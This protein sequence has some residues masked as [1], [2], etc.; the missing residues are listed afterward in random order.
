MGLTARLRAA[1]KG[2]RGGGIQLNE[3]SG[4]LAGLGESFPSRDAAGLLQL[5]TESPWLRTVVERRAIGVGS[6]RWRLYVGRRSDGRLYRNERL[7]SMLSTLPPNDRRQ[8]LNVL[9]EQGGIVEIQNHGLLSVLGGGQ[10]LLIGLTLKQ[11]TS[12]Y[13]DI[14]GEAFWLLGRDQQFGF[15]NA[16]LPVPPHW[17]RKT[18]TA[19]NPYYE[20]NFRELQMEIPASEVIRFHNPNPLNPYARG[21]GPGMSV[22]NEL[23]IDEFMRNHIASFYHNRARPDVVVSGKDLSPAKTIQL[24]KRWLERMQG[25]FKSFLPFFVAGEVDVKPITQSFHEME[26]GTARKHQRDVIQQAFGLPPTIMGNMENPTRAGAQTEDFI[27]SKWQIEPALE[28]QCQTM[29]K[30]LVP[31]YDPGLL[32]GYDSPIARDNEFQLRAMIAMPNT[33]Q[34]NEWRGAQGLPPDPAMR[35]IYV[36]SNRVTT[37]TLDPEDNPEKFSATPPPSKPDD[38]EDDT[39]TSPDPEPTEEPDGSKQKPS[40]I[41]KK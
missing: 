12:I 24:E 2:F 16:A 38:E 19:E 41:K 25:V 28:M 14:L 30:W 27:F 33:V 13:L 26:V 23:N 8:E 32:L 7:V 17:I 18:P 21:S 6:N 29:Q 5:Y 15:P 20:I 4:T 9:I 40:S 35:G 36:V 1:A 22:T 39:E 37:R 11:L 10:T 31:M 34:V 3:E